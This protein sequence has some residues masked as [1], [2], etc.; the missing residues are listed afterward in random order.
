MREVCAKQV[1]DAVARLFLEANTCLPEDVE[2]A[3]RTALHEESSPRARQ[4]LSEIL[5]NAAIA[6]SERIAMC[7]DT[8]VAYVFLEIGQHV[9]ITGGDLGDAIN[10]G[11]ARAYTDGYLRKSVVDDPIFRRKNTGDNT[12]AVVITEIVPGDRVSIWALPKG[13]GSEN[14]SAL[15]MLVPADS[16]SGIRSFVRQTVEQA[17]SNPCPPVIIGVGVGG[18]MDKA[19]LL[20]K[21]ALLR[22]LGQPHPDTDTAELERQI[23]NDINNLGLGAAGLGGNITALAVHIETYPTHIGAMPVAVNLQCHA[24]RHSH[25]VL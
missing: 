25:V 3:V 5:E 14:M 22:P 23:L 6:R 11:V 20:A 21:K 12:P 17:G 19:A 2:N 16:V 4:V 1:E 8:G 18:M 15:K 24:A 13:T 9:H 10:K 7:Q